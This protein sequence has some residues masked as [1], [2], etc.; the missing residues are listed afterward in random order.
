MVG[1]A[2]C[3]ELHFSISDAQTRYPT[4]LGLLKCVLN[5]SLID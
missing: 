3:V 2:G 1:G 5:A 4:D